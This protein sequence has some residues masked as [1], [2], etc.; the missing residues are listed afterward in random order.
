MAQRIFHGTMDYAIVDGNLPI[1]VVHVKKGVHPVRSFHDHTYCEI[2]VVISGQA[3]HILDEESVPISAGDVLLIHPG[4]IHA[5]DDAE[6]MEIINL[7]F[8]F[9]H[10]SLPLLDGCSMPLFRKIF[11]EGEKPYHSAKPATFLGPEDLTEIVRMLRELENELK[12]P[13][14]GKLF[15]SLMLFM[16]ILVFLCRKSGQKGREKQIDSLIG[17]VIHYMQDHYAED[18]DL[19]KLAKIAKMSDRSFFRHFR[20]S[21]NCS[22]VE[23]LLKLRLQHSCELLV[24][25]NAFVSEIASLCGFYDSNYFCKQFR[26][27]F[28]TSP[29]EFRKQYSPRPQ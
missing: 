6:Q 17:N 24:T 4:A 21:T 9:S 2:V 15:S 28:G 18:V 29:R 11:P 27:A 26:R 20:M 7:T 16:E 5:Y 10:L 3:R 8:D 25:G 12:D 19:K 13:R 1:R 22:P 23:Y 14:P